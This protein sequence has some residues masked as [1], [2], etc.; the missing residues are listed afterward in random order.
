MIEHCPNQ[1]GEERVCLLEGYSPFREVRAGS[2]ASG[3]LETGAAA[4]RERSAP[5]CPPLACS[6]LLHITRDHHPRAGRTSMSLINQD[7]IPQTWPWVMLMEA[8][9]Q[10]RHSSLCQ[11]D[12]NWPAHWAGNTQDLSVHADT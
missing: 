2:G 9:P 7:D 4:E 6:L 12:R 11:V 5:A 1:L 10:F 8:V 3:N